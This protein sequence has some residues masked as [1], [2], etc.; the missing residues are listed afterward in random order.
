[1]CRIF[2]NFN[3]VG[4]EA[5]GGAATGGAI[6]AASVADK[7]IAGKTTVKATR[8]MALI[9]V[10]AAALG[11]IGCA[12]VEYPYFCISLEQVAGIQVDKTGRVGL[13]GLSGGAVV[14]LEYSLAR[15]G[16]TLEFAVI[17]DSAHPAV[18]VVI[19]GTDRF[20]QFQPDAT[21]RAANGVPCASYYPVTDVRFNFGW[22]AGCT[23]AK[24][25]KAIQ[26]DVIDGNGKV[27]ARE[28]IAFTLRENG[29]Y[30]ATDSI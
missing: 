26:F 2:A 25:I 17:Q 4:H 14:P 6:V 5:K 29:S 30:T 16:Y 22:D 11:S 9:G 28:R 15:N 20:L 8:S 12:E 18:S 1:M 19:A 24:L 21:I 10:F 13:S 7:T 23:A 27:I 3:D